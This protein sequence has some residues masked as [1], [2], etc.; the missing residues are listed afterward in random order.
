MTVN[1]GPSIPPLPP[2]HVRAGKHSSA[3]SSA[4]RAVAAEWSAAPAE[5]AVVVQSPVWDRDIWRSWECSAVKLGPSALWG[6]IYAALSLA[7][8]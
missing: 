7:P 5:A 3:R 8:R 6:R 4:A 1:Y 2:A